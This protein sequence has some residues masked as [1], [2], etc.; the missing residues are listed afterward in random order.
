[1]GFGYGDKQGRFQEEERDVCDWCEGDS[2][3]RQITTISQMAELLLSQIRQERS[4]W[5][6]AFYD[7]CG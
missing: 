6:D 3:S 1:M 4:D 5:L 2:R 7:F